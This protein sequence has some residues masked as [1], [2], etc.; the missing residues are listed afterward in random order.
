MLKFWRCT[1]IGAKKRG[2]S[3]QLVCK[4]PLPIGPC[5]GTMYKVIE[6]DYW[7]MRIRLVVFRGA[8]NM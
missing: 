2:F 5:L 3:R 1:I 7:Y 6:S 8:G 4:Q